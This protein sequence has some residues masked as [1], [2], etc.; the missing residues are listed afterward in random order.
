M[1][2]RAEPTARIAVLRID[3]NFYPSY[4]DAL[5][6][7][8]DRVPVGGIVILDDVLSHSAVMQFWKDFRHDQGLPEKLVRI[9]KMSAWFRKQKDVRVDWSEFHNFSNGQLRRHFGHQQLAGRR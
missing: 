9:D 3:G 7:L 4:Q 2:A 5:Y 6:H 1:F 8:Y